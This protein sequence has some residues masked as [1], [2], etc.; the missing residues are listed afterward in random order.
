[1]GS[2]AILAIES[3]HHFFQPASAELRSHLKDCPA[4]IAP[5]AVLEDA[6]DSCRSPQIALSVKKQIGIRLGAVRIEPEAVQNIL[7]PGTI[8]VR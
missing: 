2:N 8:A 3:K 6:A 5:G 4:A 7:S 1:M